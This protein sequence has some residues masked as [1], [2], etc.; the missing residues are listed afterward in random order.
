M[1][2]WWLSVPYTLVTDLL[3]IL[4]NPTARV[5]GAFLNAALLLASCQILSYTWR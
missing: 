4:P 1:H 3:A 2:I 5:A